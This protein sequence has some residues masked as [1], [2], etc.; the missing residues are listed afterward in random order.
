MALF[1]GTTRVIFTRSNSI[2]SEACRY[3]ISI[4]YV[5]DC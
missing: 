1:L 3:V 5:A 2:D 4:W